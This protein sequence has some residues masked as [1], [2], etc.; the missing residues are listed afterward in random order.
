MTEGR[1][2]FVLWQGRVPYSRALDL[3]MQICELKKH[4]FDKDVLL[5]LEHPPTITM[6]RSGNPDHLLIKE[7]SLNLFYPTE[8]SEEFE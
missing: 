4:G 8:E 2:C 1:D 3:Q 6:G 5:L 7:E